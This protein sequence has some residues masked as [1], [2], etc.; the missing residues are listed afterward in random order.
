M[1][2]SHWTAKMAVFWTAKM[3]VFWTAK[4]AVFWTA[5]MAVFLASYHDYFHE[6]KAYKPLGLY[7]L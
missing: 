4:M 5:K 7:A 1:K 6:K 3:A 2:G